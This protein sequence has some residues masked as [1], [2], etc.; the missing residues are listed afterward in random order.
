MATT[1]ETTAVNDGNDPETPLDHNNTDNNKKQ[2]LTTKN[3]IEFLLNRTLQSKVCRYC[4][5]VTSDLVEVDMML[6][7]GGQKVLYDITIKDMIA[8]FYP[9]Q[10]GFLNLLFIYLISRRL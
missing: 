1:V 6:H 3:A 7:V 8:N 4:L 2:P 10:V 5:N 9:F